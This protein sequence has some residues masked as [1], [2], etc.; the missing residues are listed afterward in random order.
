M[1]SGTKCAIRA[2]IHSTETTAGAE[3]ITKPKIPID[4]DKV[5]ELAARGQSQEQIAINLGVS[6]RTIDHRKKDSAEFA[7]AIKLGHAQALQKVENVLFEMATSGENTAATIFYLKTH[8]KAEWS[9]K[10]QIDV[11]SSAPIQVQ[12]I[13]D[14]KE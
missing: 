11:T 8:G 4:L 2:I 9:E 12:I 5:R 6:A 14:L 13:N 3:M 10:Q 1:K 7:E